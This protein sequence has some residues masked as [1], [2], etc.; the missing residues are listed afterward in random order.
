MTNSQAKMTSMFPA[1]DLAK[2]PAMQDTVQHMAELR[3][4]TIHGIETITLQTGD[5]PNTVNV[6]V[7]GLDWG[8][9]ERILTQEPVR[10]VE[11]VTV[12]E[13]IAS[14]DKASADLAAIV[15]EREDIE[16]TD[17]VKVETLDDGHTIFKVNDAEVGSS[18]RMM[19]AEIKPEPAKIV[20]WKY[21]CEKCGDRTEFKSSWAKGMDKERTLCGGCFEEAKAELA[22]A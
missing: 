11:I 3:G 2:L 21:I 4:E 10:E 20:D 13:F 17:E 22:K 9:V 19:I 14:D 1:Q 5:T 18:S 8:M 12:E 15:E 6:F 16:V 7:D